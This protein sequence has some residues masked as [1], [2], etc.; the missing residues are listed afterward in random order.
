MLLIG[1]LA[2]RMAGDNGSRDRRTAGR[3]CSLGSVLCRRSTATKPVE[4]D[5]K[6]KNPRKRKLKRDE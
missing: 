1:A 4:F 2:R 6:R 3:R 5:P